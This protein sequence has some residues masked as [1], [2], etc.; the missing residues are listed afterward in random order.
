[1]VPCLARVTSCNT[2]RFS[3]PR[4][5]SP[6]VVPCLTTE[7]LCLTSRFL[8]RGQKSGPEPLG[9]GDAFF[10]SAQHREAVRSSGVGFP[11]AQPTHSNHRKGFPQLL[12]W[13]VAWG[14]EQSRH[15]FPTMACALGVRSRTATRE[16]VLI[17]EKG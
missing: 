5:T 14:A 6:G 7:E 17:L 9:T 12:G 10:T 11:A 8:R 4:D 3:S 13:Q 2:L 16:L 15:R 1:M